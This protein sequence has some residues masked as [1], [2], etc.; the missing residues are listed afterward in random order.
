M[1]LRHGARDTQPGRLIA[2]TTPASEVFLGT[3]RMARTPVD[4]E[5]DP[6]TY[7]L[8]FKHPRRAN[9]IKRVTISAGKTTK[10]TFAL[11]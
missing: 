10:L 4:L 1:R 3:R 6:G 8:V 9:T 5:L 11:P 7:T 2:R